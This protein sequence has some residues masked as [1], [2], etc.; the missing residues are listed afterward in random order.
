MV[1]G[2]AFGL[3][4]LLCLIL[5]KTSFAQTAKTPRDLEALGLYVLYCSNPD[6]FFERFYSPGC[7]KSQFRPAEEAI[8]FGDL[9]PQQIIRNGVFLHLQRPGEFERFNEAELSP[10]LRKRIVGLTVFLQADLGEVNLRSDLLSLSDL[11]FQGTMQDEP[12]K[13]MIVMDFAIEGL[14]HLNITAIQHIEGL[15]A[16]RNLRHLVLW[17]TG[18][19]DGTR[20]ESLTQIEFISSAGSELKTFPDLSTLPSLRY[21]DAETSIAGPIDLVSR[22]LR[23]LDLTAD[24]LFSLGRLEMPS[25]SRMTIRSGKLLESMPPLNEM[26]QL[27]ELELRGMNSL[28]SMPDISKLT[29][30]KRLYLSEMNSMSELPNLEPLQELRS[31]SLRFQDQKPDAAW[32]RYPSIQKLRKLEY[33]QLFGP[34]D[35]PPPS[36]ISSLAGLRGLALTYSGLSRDDFSEVLTMK[37]L[38]SLLLHSDFVFRESDT[39]EPFRDWFNRMRAQQN[40]DPVK[41]RVYRPSARPPSPPKP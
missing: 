15:E 1:R 22:S 36:G 4:F 24:R 16:Q 35:L 41:V 33:L 38:E 25:L 27:E 12:D 8:S 3:C 28:R 2:F 23:D 32:P 5:S 9:L 20:L 34:E 13:T 7:I 19:W 30:L 31:L 18:I 6:D 14:T 26:K 37:N 21:L 11:T 17:D 40:L 10:N 39:Q 29:G